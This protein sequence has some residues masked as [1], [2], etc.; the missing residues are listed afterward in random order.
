MFLLTLCLVLPLYDWHLSPVI[1]NL[2]RQMIWEPIRQ[3]STHEP[4]FKQGEDRH[5]EVAWVPKENFTLFGPVII[6]PLGGGG[7]FGAKQ[8]EI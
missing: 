7:G 8:G 1:P 6:Y 5:L 2:H 4:P 3:V